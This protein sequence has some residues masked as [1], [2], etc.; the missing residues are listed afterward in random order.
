MF[1]N[2]NFQEAIRLIELDLR[3]ITYI[4]SQTHP[5]RPII[6]FGGA[7]KGIQVRN[8]VFLFPGHGF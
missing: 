4:P 8:K 7:S 6:K 2:E 3:V 5:H 1:D